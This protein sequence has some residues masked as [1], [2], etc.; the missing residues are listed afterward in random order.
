MIFTKLLQNEKWQL[1]RVL[2]A[3]NRSTQ[4][5]KA[6]EIVCLRLALAVQWHAVSE[7]QKTITTY[8]S[9]LPHQTVL[10]LVRSEEFLS[11]IL[12]SWTKTGPLL[13]NKHPPKTIPT[14]FFH[15][16]TKLWIPTF[17][18]RSLKG[19]SGEKL[20]DSDT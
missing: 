10:I 18:R 2:F 7:R 8:S 20:H 1:G 17:L 15:T 14:S 13:F 6:A 4:E 12:F 5:N 3:Y 11:F 16:S 9:T 19:K